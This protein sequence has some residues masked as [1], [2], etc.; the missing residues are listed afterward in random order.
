M[1][2]FEL[3]RNITIGQYLPTGSAVHGLDPRAKIVAALLLVLA[4][5]FCTSIVGNLLL[6]GLVLWLVVFSRIPVGYALRG[7]RLALPPMAVILVLQLIFLGNTE[8]AGAIFVHWGWLRVTQHSLQTIVINILRVVI[9]IILTSLITLTS[10]TTELTHGLESLMTPFRR[11]GVPAHE[12]ALIF[13]IALR[14]VPTLAEEMERIMKAQASR[15]AQMAS[16]YWRPD[17]LARAY[18]PLLVP[19]FLNALRRAE[20]LIMAMES[21]CYVSGAGRTKFVVLRSRPRDYVAVALAAGVF[22]A[23]LLVPWPSTYHTLRT[24]MGL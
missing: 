21:R 1:E 11:F 7:L 24:L 22:L 20:D 2:N 19:L 5:S 16:R 8:P 12:I 17:V 10:S 3:L 18:L 6:F 13:T 23:I 4:I 9:F 15:G 14:F